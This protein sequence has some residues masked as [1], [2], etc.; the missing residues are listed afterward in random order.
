MD[1]VLFRLIRKFIFSPYKFFKDSLYFKT[2]RY[3]GK[4]RE[5][6]F[7]VSHISQLK[8]AEI[9]I[10]NKKI[11]SIQ[12]IILYTNKNKYMPNLMMN[13]LDKKIFANVDLFILPITPNDFKLKKLI[14]MYKGYKSILNVVS[15]KNLYVFSY[16]NHYALLLKRASRLKIKTHLIEEGSSL[17]IDTEKSYYN[18][19]HNF[20]YSNCLS[21]IF[22]K[23]D[24]IYATYPNLIKSKF[25]A[26]EYKYFDSFLFTSD[27]RQTKH[28][29]MK[30]MIEENSAIFLSQRYNIPFKIYYSLLYEILLEIATKNNFKIY[31]KMHPKESQSEKDYFYNLLKDKKELFVFIDENEI[32]IENL[33][34]VSK[35]KYVFSLTSSV[36]IYSPL[37]NRNI[38]TYSIFEYFLKK[39]NSLDKYSG[40]DEIKN[41]AS[42]LKK[43]NHII[44]YNKNMYEL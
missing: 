17:Y 11:K 2:N 32:M 37:L 42:I 21:L 4:P 30:Y 19:S 18:R 44:Q 14:F 28:L 13:T 20:Y 12:L 6:L 23:F 33:I 1:F 24:V 5:N 34:N 26:K 10:K 16:E 41:H 15:P 38:K 31:I 22:T 35:I 9:F 25:N 43:F 27:N 40:L 36:L 29:I 39:I 7:I 3:V 8:R